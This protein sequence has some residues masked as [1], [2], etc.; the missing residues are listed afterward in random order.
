MVGLWGW[1]G[2]GAVRSRVG[3]LSIAG[4]ALL[5]IEHVEK[6]SNASDNA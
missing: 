1:K 3:V 6:R 5:R 2:Q 4:T